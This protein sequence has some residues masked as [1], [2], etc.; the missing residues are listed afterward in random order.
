MEP[1]NTND[2]QNLNKKQLILLTLLITFVVSIATGII[3]VSIMNQMPKAVPQT[4]NNVIQR[5]IEKVSTVEVPSVDESQNIS[6]D[7]NSQGSSSSN[8]VVLGSNDS[9]VNIYSYDQ[10]FSQEEGASYE[11]DAIGQGII[12]SDAGLI[13]VDTNILRGGESFKVLL[14]NIPFNASV[15]KSFDNGFAVLKISKII[16]GSVE[17]Q[18]ATETTNQ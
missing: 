9:L 1:E 15:L 16:E 3:T 10:E 11:K 5:T 7:N 6:T 4:I 18:S 12:I 13:L 8:A 2:I 17:S 14:E